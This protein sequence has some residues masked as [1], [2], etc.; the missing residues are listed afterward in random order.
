[1]QSAKSKSQW[2]ASNSI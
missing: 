1:V 2:L